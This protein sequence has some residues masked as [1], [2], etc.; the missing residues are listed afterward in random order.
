MESVDTDWHGRRYE[1][2]VFRSEAV[3]SRSERAI[4]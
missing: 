2:T 1:N 4:N 3:V